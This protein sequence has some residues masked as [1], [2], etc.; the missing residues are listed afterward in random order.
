[1]TIQKIIETINLIEK[2]FK[3]Y[4]I[5]FFKKIAINI[6]LRSNRRPWRFGFNEYRDWYLGNTLKDN[7]LMDSFKKSLPLPKHY[8]YRLDVRVI[9]IPWVISRLRQKSEKIL[10]A[11]SALNNIIV[12]TAPQ[13]ANK[14]ITI[15]TLAPESVCFWNKG[16][17]YVFGDVRDLDFKDETFD[18]VICISTIEHVGM[19]NSMYIR[20]QSLADKGNQKDFIIAIKELKRVLKTGGTLYCTFPFGEYENHIWFQQFDSI[21][22]DI[23]IKTFEPENYHET[24]YRYNPDGWVT[25]N[26]DSCAHCQY[27]DV[28]TSKYFDPLSTI[29]Y[30]PDYPAAERAVACLELIK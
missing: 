22:A 25:S 17:S 14:V 12:L 27:F 19:D 16:I 11:G 6:Y 24:I 7:E 13:L 29:E 5:F 3:R 26:R 1:M 20:N 4:S 21:L 30:P 18:S 2:K 23:L 8:G 28:H 10:D 9:E 15:L